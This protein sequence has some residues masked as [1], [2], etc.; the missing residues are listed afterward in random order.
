MQATDKARDFALNLAN[1][2]GWNNPLYTYK[3]RRELAQ[4]VCRQVSYDFGYKKQFGWTRL[5][6]WEQKVDK[7]INSGD[8]S[9]L[10]TKRPG[11]K[12]YID[13]IESKH[14]G[15]VR[16]LFRHSQKKLG[17]LANFEDLTTCMNE[18]SNDPSETRTSLTLHTR[19][20]WRWFRRSGGKEKRPAEKPR[21]TD[22]HK[23]QRIIWA[24]KW[25]KVLRDRKPYAFLD[26]KWFYTTSRRRKIKF[27]PP[28]KEEE[29][30]NPKLAV[31]K[32]SKIVSRRHVQKVM[33]LGVVACPVPN[34]HFDGRILMRRVAQEKTTKKAS[35]HQRF[36]DDAILNSEI[37]EGK[38]REF[39]TDGMT[40][41]TFLSIL[42]QTYDLWQEIYVTKCR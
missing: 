24:R 14:P 33:Y 39:Y 26:E 34:K 40:V 7:A 30:E 38:W 36:T 41:S 9:L 18:L 25:K 2:W 23:N 11:R 37:R 29:Q 21:L 8:V 15:Y 31:P 10:E 3:E 4:A 13:T 17:Y 5:F 28:T 12:S 35:S 16:E 22:D 27:L 19:Q 20:V 32:Q 1:K 42:G 6:V